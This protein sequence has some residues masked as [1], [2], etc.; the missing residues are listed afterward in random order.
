MAKQKLTPIKRRMIKSL[1]KSLGVVT[2]AARNAKIARG[3]HY[4][5][6]NDDEEY[7][8]EVLAL[9]DMVID[10]AETQL[11]KQIQSGNT[12]ATIFYLKTKGR[13]R[14]YIERKEIDHS[15]SV[16]SVPISD[17]AKAKISEILDNE[18]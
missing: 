9:D 3:T 2:T 8:K 12:T 10:F 7:K 16:S 13:N 6:M 11:H 18:Y 4:L 15:G 14:G 1:E 17:E 5:W